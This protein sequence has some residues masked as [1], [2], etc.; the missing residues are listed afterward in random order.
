MHVRTF[1]T[2][3]RISIAVVPRQQKNMATHAEDFLFTY[4]NGNLFKTVARF[5]DL[6]EILYL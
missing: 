6:G 3:T 4:N 5:T 1:A 2:L